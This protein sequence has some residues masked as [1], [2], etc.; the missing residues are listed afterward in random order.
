[1]KL[2]DVGVVVGAAFIGWIVGHSRSAESPSAGP[3]MAEDLT[4]GEENIYSI[5]QESIKNA[6]ESSNKAAETVTTA[7]FSIATAYGA[8]V[9][10]VTPETRPLEFV[11]GLPIVLF[12]A[13]AVIALWSRSRI[14]EV[15]DT[16]DLGRIIDLTTSHITN[17][18]MGVRGAVVGL[19]IAVIAA[20]LVVA[21]SYE[22]A[23][24]STDVTPTTVIVRIEQ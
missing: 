3:I 11:I 10:L 16:S 22:P 6:L 15:T 1:M 4:A 12:V 14:I 18:R 13:A 5:Y 2:E 17:K 21:Y 24:Q 20:T 8:L 23:S 9:A 19:A 7:A